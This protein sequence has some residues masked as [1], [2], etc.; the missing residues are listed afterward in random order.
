[1]TAFKN[2][3][4]LDTR[5]VARG[6]GVLAETVAVAEKEEWFLANVLEGNGATPGQFVF[7]RED[8]EERLGEKHKRFEF[9]ATNRK[10]E[11]GDVDDAGAEAVEEH[12]SDFFDHGEPHRREFFRKGGEDAR[13]EIRSDGGNGANRHR[14][15]DGLFLLDDVATRGFEFAQDTA[16]ARKKCLADFGEADGAAETVEEAGAEFVF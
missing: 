3:L 7:L 9:V 12:G 6:D 13:E 10:S 16:C 8:G 11:D 1:M 4:R 2:H 15:A 5:A 14:T